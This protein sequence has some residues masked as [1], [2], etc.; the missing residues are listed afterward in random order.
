VRLHVTW[1]EF[2]RLQRATRDKRGYRV[3]WPEF[4]F[5]VEVIFGKDLA[6]EILRYVE[7]RQ[8]LPELVPHQDLDVAVSRIER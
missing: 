7:S 6:A 1:G 5:L 8:T 2:S 4:P 3:Q